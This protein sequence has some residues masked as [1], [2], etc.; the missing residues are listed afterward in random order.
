M[1]VA[2]YQDA[3]ANLYS[4]METRTNI[5]IAVGIILGQSRCTQKEAFEMLQRASSTRGRKLSDVA[6]DL[7]V[8]ATG[9]TPHTHFT[10]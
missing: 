9:T 6:R 7:I 2:R 3:A 4:A 5:D 1:R 8:Q 10:N